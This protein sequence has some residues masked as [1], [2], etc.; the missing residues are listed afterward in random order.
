MSMY[1]KVP[2]KSSAGQI[3]VISDFLR[4][5]PGSLGYDPGLPVAREGLLPSVKGQITDK[6]YAR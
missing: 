2:Q 4:Y 6:V 3:A 5:M 1:L